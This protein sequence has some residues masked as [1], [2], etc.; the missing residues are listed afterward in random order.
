MISQSKQPKGVIDWDV[1]NEM[2][3]QGGVSNH[4]YY[5]DQSGNPN[6]R[7]EIHKHIKQNFPQNKQFV[8]DYGIILDRNNRFSMFQDLLR[9]LIASGA[10]I[11][12]IGLQSHINGKQTRQT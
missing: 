12:G 5:M 8:N 10:P 11:D 7:A 4:T 1:I 3:D 2:V 6:I 9:D